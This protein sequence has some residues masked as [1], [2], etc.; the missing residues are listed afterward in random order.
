[1]ATASF[2]KLIKIEVEE[3]FRGTVVYCI[4]E[5]RGGCVRE[6]EFERAAVEEG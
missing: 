1:M 6:G 3:V 5:N 2:G 4:S